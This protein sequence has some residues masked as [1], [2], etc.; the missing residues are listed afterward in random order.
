MDEIKV[1]CRAPVSH[2]RA[3]SCKV[4][5][6]KQSVTGAHINLSLFSYHCFLVELLPEIAQKHTDTHIFLKKSLNAYLEN[7]I[8]STIHAYS[9]PPPPSL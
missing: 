4:G 3:K 7:K 6:E 9:F 1:I 8:L 2:A 5:A